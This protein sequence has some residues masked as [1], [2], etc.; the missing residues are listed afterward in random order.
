MT[1]YSLDILLSQYGISLLFHVQFCC[2]L[3]SIQL[4]QEA[5]KVVWYR[6]LLMNV[7]QF[8]VIHIVKGFGV[9]S[10]AEVDVSLELSCSFNNPTGVGNLI[11]GS[12]AFSKY[13]LNIWK[14]TVHVLLKPCLG[15]FEHFIASR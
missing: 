15:N 8:V 13:S 14:F 3:T 7:P 11:S 12:S 5:H 9:V 6:H 2:L 1:I 10:K 4:S